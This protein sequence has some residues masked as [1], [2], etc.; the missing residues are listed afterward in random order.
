MAK[1][2]SKPPPFPSKEEILAF[3]GD[4]PEQIVTPELRRAF[5][6]KND[7]PVDLERMRRELPSNSR[8]AD[9]Q[10]GRDPAAA[11]APVTRTEPHTNVT[12]M[13]GPT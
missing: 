4:T 6:L 12:G 13:E 5:P 7:A 9:T 10:P 8:A 1:H 11:P 3:I 2:H